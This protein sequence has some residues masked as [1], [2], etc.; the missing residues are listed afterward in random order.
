MYSE[1]V[2]IALEGRPSSR[3][4]NAFLFETLNHTYVPQYLVLS[5]SYW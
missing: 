1:S 5:A 4:G 2:G 3:F